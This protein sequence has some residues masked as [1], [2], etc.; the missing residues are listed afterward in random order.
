[1]DPLLLLKASLFLVAM[2]GAAWLLRRAPAASRHGLWTF[3]FAAILL[4]PVVSV[5]LPALDV[6]VPARWRAILPA[7]ASAGDGRSKGA[8]AVPA[9]AHT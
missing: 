6:P 4:L 7:P 8:N 2:L 9:P 3:G 5:M 1:M